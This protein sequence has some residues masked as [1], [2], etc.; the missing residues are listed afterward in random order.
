MHIGSFVP[1]S[2]YDVGAGGGVIFMDL[3][4][5]GLSGKRGEGQEQIIEGKGLCSIKA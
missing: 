4:S 2:V 5:A 1:I 3:C